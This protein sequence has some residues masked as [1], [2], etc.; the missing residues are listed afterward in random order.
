MPVKNLTLDITQPYKLKISKNE[1]VALIVY[2]PKQKPPNSKDF[3]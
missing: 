2:S 3:F 1:M